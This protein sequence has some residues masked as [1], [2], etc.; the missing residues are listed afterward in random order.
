MTN[1]ENN[2]SQDQK[3]DKSFLSDKANN[4]KNTEEIKMNKHDIQRARVENIKRTYPPGTRIELKTENLKMNNTKQKSRHFR[5]RIFTLVQVKG[6]E[7][8]RSCDH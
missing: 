5:V 8:I 3:S 7:P 6:L 4:I 2:K 1:L